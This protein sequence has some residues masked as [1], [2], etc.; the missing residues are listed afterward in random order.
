MS[1]WIETKGTALRLRWRHD[2]KRYCIG[3]GVHDNPTGRAFANQRKSQIEMDILSGHFDSTLL[4]YRPRKLGIKHTEVTVVELFEKYAANRFRDQGLSNSSKVRLKGIASKLNQYLGDKNAEKVTSSVA[5]SVVARWSETVSSRTIKERLFD[6]KAC[7]EWSEGKY[8]TAEA[9]PWAECLD[10][11]RARGNSGQSRQQNKPFTIAELQAIVSAF[12]Q[13]SHYSHYTEF[14]IFLASTACRFGEVA[15]LRWQHLGEGYTTAWIGESISRGH[16]NKKG[17]KT[18]KSRT[19]QISPTV[20]SM[21]VDRYERLTPQPEDLVFPSPTGIAIDD[22]RFR[23][24]AWK[25]IL[26]NCQIDYRSPYKIRH[27]AIS[28]ALSNGANFIALAEQTGHDKRVML[29]TYAHAIESKC[30]FVDIGVI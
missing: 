20:I 27:S 21:L 24:R 9:N 22:H 15:G 4:K 25:T 13:H 29:S 1:I 19:I 7:W 6:L 23:A 10:R 2:G 17:T 3:L 30:L 5:K 28:H 12:E 18:G 8:H 11:A 26:E 14:V 16:Q